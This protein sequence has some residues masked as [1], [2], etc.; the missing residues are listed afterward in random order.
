MSILEK[1]ELVAKQVYG[2][3]KVDFPEH[4]LA[5]VKSLEANGFGHLPVCIAKTH[6]LISH[7]PKLKGAPSGY[8]FPIVQLEVSA[9]AG[10]VYALAGEISTM[11]GLTTRPAFFDIS[12]DWR[13]GQVNGLF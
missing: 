11:P 6:L 13:T 5:K 4:V 2:A 7:D 9:G 8:T 10:F 3:A 1:I 12:L